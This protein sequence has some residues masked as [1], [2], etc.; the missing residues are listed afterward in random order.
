[1]MGRRLW[2]GSV[3]AGLVFA[4]HLSS[5]VETFA[6]PKG[7]SISILVSYSCHCWTSSHD[8]Y[9]HRGMVRI[10]DGVRPR[11]FDAARYETSQ[12]LPDFMRNLMQHRVYVAASERNYGCYN[13]SLVDGDGLAYT[14][15]FTI[16]P[17]RGRFN[18]RRHALLL[19][20]ESAYTRMQPDHGMKTSMSAILSAAL[21]GE[22][23]IYRR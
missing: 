6:L 16:R 9:A 12:Q 23:I 11:V 22:M 18:G 2:G 3:E 4:E 19:R 20:V 10:Y 14:A 15:F 7:D 13:A 5:H 17:D 8:E 1:M 21:K